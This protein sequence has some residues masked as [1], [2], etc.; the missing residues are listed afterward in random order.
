MLLA[1]QRLAHNVRAVSLQS[2]TTLLRVR[3]MRL[4]DVDV[5][6]QAGGSMER[7]R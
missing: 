5:S 6:T 3:L 4:F 7:V 1:A 2:T